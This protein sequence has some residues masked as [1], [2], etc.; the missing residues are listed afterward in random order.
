MSSQGGRRAASGSRMVRLAWKIRQYPPTSTGGQTRQGYF[1]AAVKLSSL[2]LD[3]TVD[4]LYMCLHVC[5]VG[6]EEI[7]PPW[8]HFL[9]LLLDK[10]GKKGGKADRSLP[11]GEVSIEISL[12]HVSVVASILGPPLQAV[13]PTSLRHSP[14]KVGRRCRTR[15]VEWHQVCDRPGQSARLERRPRGE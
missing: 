14:L 6:R 7:T 2:Y 15:L 8:T 3:N 5:T 11:V 12:N 1:R 9:A 4:S 10:T 13:A